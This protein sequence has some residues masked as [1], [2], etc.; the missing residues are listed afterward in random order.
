[1]TI[2]PKHT[3]LVI[4]FIIWNYGMFF[5]NYCLEYR[6]QFMELRNEL[7]KAGVSGCQAPAEFRKHCVTLVI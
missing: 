7:I 5:C 4:K 3:V 2:T 6:K 1:M